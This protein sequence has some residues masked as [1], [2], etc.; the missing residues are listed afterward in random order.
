[1]PGP[2]S[3][4]II[5]DMA[6]TPGT[7]IRFIVAFALLALVAWRVFVDKRTVE[8]DDRLTAMLVIALVTVLVLP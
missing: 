3:R 5:C 8:A 7:V 1:M 4:V 2:C 6:P